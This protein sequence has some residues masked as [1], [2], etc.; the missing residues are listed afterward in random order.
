MDLLAALLLYMFFLALIILVSLPLLVSSFEL[1]VTVGLS[2][3]Q[4]YYSPNGA[5]CH[6][7]VGTHDPGWFRSTLYPVRNSSIDAGVV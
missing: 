3:Q 5:R 7:V 2:D 1:V 4:G 6:R